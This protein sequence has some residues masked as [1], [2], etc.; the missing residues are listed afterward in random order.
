MGIV[1]AVEQL[2]AMAAKRQYKEAAGQL[3]VCHQASQ[4]IIS[5]NLTSNFLMHSIL[6]NLLQIYEGACS[7]VKLLLIHPIQL[8]PRLTGPLCITLTF[9]S[10]N[11]PKYISSKIF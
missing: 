11:H 2:Q 9:N 3:E 5:W 10:V 6:K 4:P 7:G 1:S 8:R